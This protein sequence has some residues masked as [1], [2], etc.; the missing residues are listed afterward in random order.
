MLGV[1]LALAAS[2][3]WGIADFL[4]GL[5]TKRLPILT[6][7]AVSQF[8][9]LVCMALVVA[10][11]GRPPNATAIWFGLGAGACGA[12]GLAALYSGLSIGPMGVVAPIAALSGVVPVAWGLIRGDRPGPWQLIGIVLAVGGVVLAARQP[13]PKGHRVTSRAVAFGAIAA[14]TLGVL[15]TLLDTGARHDVGWSVLAVR[16]G[17]LSLLGVVLLVRR[18]SFTMSRGELATLGV[19]G[20]FD[21]GANL[22][23]ALAS[24]TGQLLSLLAVLASLYPV[25]TIMLARAALHERLARA[26]V[27]GVVL[28]FA[29]VALIAAG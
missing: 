29:G 23:F 6:V 20:I 7:S 21:N 24:S 10:F 27:V 18:P 12:V 15:V 1:M 4:G 14:V 22:L 13:G 8:A 26:Q 5:S 25:T 11:E 9:G 19:V 28:A 2:T 3:G 16:V 17:A